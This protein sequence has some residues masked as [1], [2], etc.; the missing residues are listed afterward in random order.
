[1]RWIFL[2]AG[3]AYVAVLVIVWSA[4]CAASWA[5]RVIEGADF[6]AAPSRRCPV[7]DSTDVYVD[8]DDICLCITCRASYPLSNAQRLP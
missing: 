5:D 1:M 3:I 8:V 7:C 4:L 6:D 2:A